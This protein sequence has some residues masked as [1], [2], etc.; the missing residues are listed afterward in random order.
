[1]EIEDFVTVILA[2]F[3][4]GEVRM[5]NCGHHPPVKLSAGA[6]TT[7]EQRTAA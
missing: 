1:M 4:P 7:A 3:G 5:V 6:S 2:E